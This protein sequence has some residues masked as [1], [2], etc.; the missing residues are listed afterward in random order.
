MSAKLFVVH[1]SHPCETV[2]RALE[3]KGIAFSRIE[4]PPA[5]HAAAM[6]ALFGKRTVPGI[7]FEDG[8]KLTG[9]R[10]ILRRLDQMVPAP[11]LLP[12]DRAARARVLEAEEWGDE[13]LQAATRRIFWPTLLGHAECAPG[14]SEGAQMPLP[15]A[16]TK[17]LIPVIGRVELKLNE[18]NEE[19]RAADLAALPGWLDTIDGWLADGTL[20]GVDAPNAADLQ[21]AP[22]LKL[23]MSMEDLRLL[24]GPRPCGAWADALFGRATGQIPAGA[25][26]ASALPA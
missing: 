3:L 4:F 13:V 25:I 19:I 12:E 17:A 26:P 23:L 6:K 16:V 11:A 10:A 7:R 18:T 21:I 2:A 9:S 22:S 24:I 5:M 14:F 20:G 15:G 8:E 1:G